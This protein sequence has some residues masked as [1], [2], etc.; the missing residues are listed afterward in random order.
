MAEK[1]RGSIVA[2]GTINISMDTL[3]RL[4]ESIT[5]APIRKGGKWR[6]I[7][8]RPGEGSSGKY[9]ADVLKRD[10]S[11]I[12]PAGAQCFINHD[13]TRSPRD[14]V[15]VYENAAS[16]DEDE[17]AV[18]AELKV[19]SHFQE[20]VDEVGP[21]CGISLY[22]LGEKDDD[23]NI[24]SFHEDKYNGADLVARPGLEG[25]GLAE[26]LSEAHRVQENNPGVELSAQEGKETKDMDEVKEAITALSTKIDALVNAQTAKV[27]EDAQREADKSAVEEA[28]AAYDAKVEEIEAARESLLPSQV[29]NLRAEAKAGNDIT[30]LIESYK[31]M[32]EEARNLLLEN[33]QAPAG[34]ITATETKSVAEFGKA[35]G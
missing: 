29:S 21:H 5:D 9:S 22:A 34:R 31:A 1:V 13:I 30:P 27:E 19:F 11:K 24:T 8:A 7:V 33:G 4:R 25:S 2:Y 12:V 15:G 6:V 16:W 26:K 14:M 28:V 3:T 17:Q 23:D 18:V 10:A 32:N 35:F 20:F